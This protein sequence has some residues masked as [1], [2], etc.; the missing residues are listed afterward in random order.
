MKQ[1]T[2]S[3]IAFAALAAAGCATPA[4]SDDRAASD[5]PADAAMLVHYQPV[6]EWPK[7]PEG[8]ATL[9][10][11]HGD[12]AVAS[13]GDVY[14]S[15]QAT[16]KDNKPIADAMSGLQVYGDDGKYLRNVPN[17]PPDLHGFVI[18]KEG[19]AEYIYAVRL[20]GQAILKMTLDGKE[21]L[22]IPGTAI[23]DQHKLKDKDGKVQLRLSG[24]DVAPN[25]DI[26]V[27]DGYS[28]F[29]ISRF[30]KTGKYIASFG[31]ADAPYGFKTLHQIAIDT[32]YEPARIIATDRANNRMVHLS[33]D[34]Q[35][36]GDYATNLLTPADVQIV[37]DHA[38]IAELK[39]QISVLDKDGKLVGRFGVNAAADGA[40]TTEPA[41]WQVGVLNTPHGIGVSAK[42][43]VF[44]SEFNVYGRSDR[45]NKE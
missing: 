21:V 32:R 12:V 40:R 15:V 23:P 17:A 36:L 24:V 5:T 18:K 1:L 44:V 16:D 8:R 37:G 26:Y 11:M 20:A 13:N 19:D 7:L 3:L 35:F 9:G 33:L 14:I 42:G 27:T 6:A 22:N 31:G 30:D 43:D 2:F 38:Y 25:G 4:S 28:S 41:K 10:N 45:F 39:G 29:N 34:G